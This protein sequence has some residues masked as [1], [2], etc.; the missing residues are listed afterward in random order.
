MMTNPSYRSIWKMLFKGEL[1]FSLLEVVAAVFIAG[2]VVVGSVVVLG[3]AVRSAADTSGSLELQQL[4][5]I[6][7]ETIQQAKFIEHPPPVLDASN[8]YPPLDG[9]LSKVTVT[10]VDGVVSVSFAL[11]NKEGD[12]EGISITIKISDAGTNYQ[13]PNNGELVL[14]VVQRVDVTATEEPASVTM[15]FYKISVP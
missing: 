8:T 14:N 7:I 13:F 12:P 15:S 5:Q 1:G 3:T 2:T 6:Q 11:A 4:V 10:S 9:D